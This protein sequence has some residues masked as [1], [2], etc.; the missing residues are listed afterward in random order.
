M[1]ERDTGDRAASRPARG[2]AFRLHL[3]GLA[4]SLMVEPAHAP[5][6]ALRAA[7]A[8]LVARTEDGD[9]AWRVRELRECAGLARQLGLTVIEAD[10]DRV[11]FAAGRLGVC[12][13]RDGLVAVTA[14][15]PLARLGRAQLLRLGSLWPRTASACAYRHGAR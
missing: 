2:G 8:F 6:A 5:E 4:T 12:T 10:A 9:G 7:H 3:D 13:Q 15:P 1:A 11:T 14:L